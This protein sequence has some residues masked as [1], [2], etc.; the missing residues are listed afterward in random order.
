[1]RR[2][3]VE[4]NAAV[5][6]EVIRKAASDFALAES[7]GLWNLVHTRR[8]A[9]RSVRRAYEERGYTKAA[10][11]VK[12]L[13]EDRAARAVDIVLGVEEGPRSVVRAV[14][15]EG[16]EAFEERELAA[17]LALAEGRA[18]DPAKVAEDRTALLNLYRGKGYQGVEV[19]AEVNAAE[20][21]GGAVSEAGGGAGEGEAMGGDVGVALVYKIKEGPQHTISSIEVSGQR[22]TGERFIRG[23]SGLRAGRPLT[24]EGLAMGQKRIYDTRL[25]RSVNIG[26]EPEGAPGKVE[27]QV[28][29]RVSLEVRETPPVT[30]SYGL[31][32]NSEEKL[33][34]FG[35]IDLRSPFG[36]GLAGLLAFRRNARQSDLRF[37]VESNY[38]FGVRFNLLSTVY[39][40]RD[41]RDL[42]T[43]DETGLTLQSRFE[44]PSKFNLSAL[45]RMNRIHQ[46]DPEAPGSAIEDKVFVSEIA[47]LLLRDT[48]DDLLDPKRG[49]FLSAT[50]T[51]SPEFLGTQLPYVSVFG[52]Y[53]SYRRFGPGLV[54][55][56]AGRAG[57]ADAFGRELVAAKR[58]FAGGGNSVRGFTQD[59]V[60]PFDPLLGVPAGGQVV[61]VVNQELR[62]PI[63]GP[64]SGAVFYDAGAVYATLRDVRLGDV[65]HGMGLGLRMRSPVGLVRADYGFN[66]RP[67]PGEKRSVFYLSIGQAF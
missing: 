20:T 47:G 59:G 38:L 4:G 42:F 5:A 12:R 13:E 52:Q 53:Q 22:R 39:T 63:F 58:F 26:S 7:R 64:A 27:G 24:S 50:A 57:V 37:S 56:A 54:W 55:A 51:W 36:E 10:I 18:F 19:E 15:F 9:L 21:E 67:R 6:D 16:R 31:R 43:A 8:L 46:Y 65:R 40:K 23:A 62:F 33:E 17:A 49:S 45:Y 44:L 66:L 2:F 28:M 32:Y 1:M 11:E 29:E 60:G 35:E 3:E 41:V 48:R 34:G 61:V 30:L 25:F 14:A